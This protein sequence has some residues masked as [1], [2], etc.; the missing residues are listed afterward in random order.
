[1]RP[2]GDGYIYISYS[3]D[4]CAIVH[5]KHN[6][7]EEKVADYTQDNSG[8]KVPGHMKGDR[9]LSDVGVDMML[10]FISPWNRLCCGVSMAFPY[11]LRNINHVTVK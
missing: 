3:E 11:D 4:S 9:W 6:Q 8:L 2:S 1:M 10:C 7:V 5:C